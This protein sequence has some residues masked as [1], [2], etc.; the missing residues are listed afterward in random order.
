M[1]QTQTHIGKIKEI[2]NQE[3]TFESKLV[4][5]GYSFNDWELEDQYIDSDKYIYL[6][7]TNQLFEFV[8]HSE[9]EYETIAYGMTNPDG[10]ISFI[11]QFYDGGTCLNEV[12]ED[13]IVKINNKDN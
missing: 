5:I 4:A 10:T 9:P 8:E 1:S 11:A 3:V 2:A 13:I 12:L 6:R 7:K